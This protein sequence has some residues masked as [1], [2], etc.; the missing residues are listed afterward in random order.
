[1]VCPLHNGVP[2]IWCA[3]HHA[4][5]PPRRP[6][7]SP[8]PPI[9]APTNDCELGALW[10]V[11][12]SWESGELTHIIFDGWA[13]H[14]ILSIELFNQE[15]S[16][17]KKSISNAELV[18]VR[19]SQG[20][21]TIAELKLVPIEYLHTCYPPR[22]KQAGLL[23]VEYV[24]SPRV[25]QRPRIRCRERVPPSPL[26]PP[27]PNSPP[28]LPPPPLPPPAPP[29]PSCPQPSPPPPLPPPRPP[30]PTPP[31]APPPRPGA[32]SFE[33]AV[34]PFYEAAGVALALGAFAAL[35]AGMRYARERFFT[36]E[37]SSSEC[38]ML[39]DR[40][41]TANTVMIPRKTSAA[42]W[43][44]TVTLDDGD[45]FQLSVRKSSRIDDVDALKSAI[46]H[47]LADDA[48]LG[49]QGKHRSGLMLV[50]FLAPYANCFLTA[51][52]EVPFAEVRAARKLLVIPVPGGGAKF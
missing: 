36:H 1:M 31:P 17:D 2:E 46:V 24:S 33:A 32:P 19:P 50:Q 9:Y 35:G 21:G 41:D 47:A 45:E 3:G 11:Q 14:R 23:F 51:T 34:R 27:S 25:E 6:A 48:P 5:P 20:R 13:D 37:A 38:E 52:A 40:D 10:E 22:C 28:P 8:P 44:V 42:H 49:W 7:P 43:R 39:H 12:K 15:V 4:A 30:P 26:P 16:F 29:P 18:S